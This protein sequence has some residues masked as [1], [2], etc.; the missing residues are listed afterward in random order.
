MRYVA[1][2]GQKVFAIS[3]MWI[4]LGYVSSRIKPAHLELQ[5]KLAN[6]IAAVFTH[7]LIP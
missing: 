1:G 2:T 5:Q 7:L 3:L 4:G 6:R